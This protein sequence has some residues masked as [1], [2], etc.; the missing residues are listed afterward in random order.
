MIVSPTVDFG[1]AFEALTGHLP[2][3]WQRRLFEEHFCCGTLPPAVDI[4]TGL[5]KTAVMAVWLL[6]RA[7][8]ASLPRRLVYVVDRRAVVDQ[9]TAFAEELR[10]KLREDERLEPVRRSL[11]LY[12]PDPERGGVAERLCSLPISTL[13]GQHADNR[14]WMSNPAAPAIVVGTVDMVGSRLLFEGYGVSR[15][16]RPYAAGLL[17]CDTLVMLDE[18][19]LARPFERLL[20]AIEVGQ[21][22]S[23]ADGAEVANRYFSGP[24]ASNELPPPFRVLPLSATLG[25]HP[26]SEPFGLKGD[27][28]AHETV[29]RR[30]A[31]RKSL[32]VED[33][34]AG[35]GLAD[36]LAGRAWDQMQSESA[37]ARKLPRVAVYCD[38][39]KD[40][41][42]V[43]KLLE[44]RAKKDPPEA[45]VI[46]FVGGRRVRERKEAA[47]ELEEHGLIGGAEAARSGPVFL[48][49]TSAG[50]VGID[51]DCDHMVCD[52]VAW[53]RMVQRLG[54]VNRYGRGNATVLAIDQGPPDGKKAY[55]NAVA[56]HTAVRGL[57]ETLSPDEA[58][59]RQAGPGALVDFAADPAQR[60]QIAAATTRMPLYPALTRPLVDAWAMTSLENHA[61]RPEVAP[62]LRGWVEGD[63]P[64]TAV[65]WRRYLPLRFPAGGGDAKA[66]AAREIRAFFAAAPPQALELLETETGRVVEWLKRRVRKHLKELK[67]APAPA[68]PDDDG[69]DDSKGTVER[70]GLLA[71]LTRDGPIAFLLDGANRSDRREATLSLAA[72]D[73]RSPKELQ[74]GL[75]GKRL[76][77]DA[78]L[79]GI[80]RGL[81]NDRTDGQPPTIEDDNWIEGHYG[82]GTSPRTLTVEARLADE[83]DA[84]ERDSGR[85]TDGWRDVLAVTYGETAE[86]EAKSVLVVRKRHGESE[87]EDAKAVALR[88]QRLDEHQRWAG[89]EAE[90]ISAALDLHPEDRAMLVTAAR[91]HDDGKAAPRWQRAFNAAREGGPYAKTTGSPN[92][93]LLSGYRHE[94]K[95]AL[96]AEKLGLDGLGRADAR[97]DLALHLIAAHHGQARPT[98]G[99]GGY[100]ELPPSE[101]ETRAHA[102]AL[103][104]ARLQRQW[105]PWG[106][107]W[108]E[109]LLRAADQAA[110]R[111][112]DEGAD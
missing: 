82:P 86:G 67:K 51:L 24:A 52:L 100:D 87:S 109:A 33:L 50:E 59:G 15:R 99:V 23:T 17:G 30:L 26:D 110:S 38:R 20:R 14:E 41:E 55:E 18:A 96:D 65:V 5:G 74:A 39:R 89:E 108:W 7:A 29:R 102:I 81:L 37:T 75:A 34:E 22:R 64:Q 44:V 60:A 45:A 105:G 98:I 28:R 63:E 31:A 11:C 84:P 95:S 36:V 58:G 16:M 21:R 71:P 62:W 68:V 48:V 3:P 49:A 91:H 69:A 70:Q 88:A 57:L 76:V 40:A 47:E 106:L 73:G 92:Q 104:F 46:L 72:I 101:A 6:A 90:R 43:A 66:P 112:L 79:G 78:R 2:F 53:E 83:R 93:H 12:E 56:R 35:A 10:Q 94:L 77:V 27:D 85:G 42:R 80:E 107:A 4:P 25:D 111:R 19:H 103:R 8:G 1:E 97:F 54:R 9:A 13:R 61:G 32:R